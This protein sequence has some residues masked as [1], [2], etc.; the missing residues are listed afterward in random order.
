MVDEIVAEFD[1]ETPRVLGCI[2]GVGVVNDQIAAMGSR[3]EIQLATETVL[4]SRMT[5]QAHPAVES[6]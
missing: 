6:P 4:P 2:H 3:V 1:V 5:N